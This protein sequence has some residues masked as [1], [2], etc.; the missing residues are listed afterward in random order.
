MSR[1]R[2]GAGVAAAC[3]IG[4]SAVKGQGCPP[5]R[6]SRD[7]WLALPARRFVVADS[8]RGALALSLMECLSHRDPTL[9]DAVAVSALSSWLRGR[10]LPPETVGA[11]A[12]RGLTLLTSPTDSAG[13]TQSF[14]ALV[15]SEVVRADRLDSA[16]APA[17]LAAIGYEAVRVMASLRDYR[18]FDREVGW[19]HGV[20]HAADLTLQLGLHPRVGAS[21]VEQL[22]TAL[23]SQVGAHDGHVYLESEPERM[24]RAVAFIFARGVLPLAYWDAWTRAV[25]SPRPFGSW[26]AAFESPAGRA[27]RHNVVA[28]LHALGFAARMARPT[29]L[30]ALSALVDRELRQLIAA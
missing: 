4:A 22:L 24:A 21:T 10:L 18:G 12:R 15:L 14:A 11:L 7:Q 16:L 27:R 25:A 13:L 28:F 17:V 5:P 1:R 9:R 2:W 19:R 20:A 23:A 8:V 29:P 3:V 30:E 6:E 26:S